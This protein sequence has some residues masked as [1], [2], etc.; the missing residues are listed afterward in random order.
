MRHVVQDV[1][2]AD[3]ERQSSSMLP[4]SG[5]LQLNSSGASRLRPIS[6]AR[7]AYSSVESPAPRV[8]SGRKRFQSPAARALPFSSST[9]GWIVQRRHS[10]YRRIKKLKQL[11]GDA[12]RDFGSVAKRQ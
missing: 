11:I 6:S 12:R 7:G 9:S 5:A 10:P 8:S 3:P 2:D 4:L 1:V